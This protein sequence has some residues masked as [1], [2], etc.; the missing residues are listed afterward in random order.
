MNL[1]LRVAL[2]A[3]IAAILSGCSLNAS[4]P[5]PEQPTAPEAKPTSASKPKSDPCEKAAPSRPAPEGAEALVDL[6]D[7]LEIEGDATVDDPKK[8]A[9]EFCLKDIRLANEN[10]QAMKYTHIGLF[11]SGQCVTLLTLPKGKP[12]WPMKIAVVQRYQ[13]PNSDFGTTDRTVDGPQK[14]RAYIV[15]EEKMLASNQKC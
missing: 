13:D 14:A 4:P 7:Y 15:D 10:M 1:K 9:K 6:W 8:L 12:A 11:K 2:V 5:S 3:F